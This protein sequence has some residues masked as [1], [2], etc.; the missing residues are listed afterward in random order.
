MQDQV[1]TRWEHA[2]LLICSKIH[3]TDSSSSGWVARRAGT[4]L[5]RWH[6]TKAA[7]SVPSKGLVQSMGSM[8]EAASLD[9]AVITSGDMQP[10]NMADSSMLRDFWH[11]HGNDLETMHHLIYEVVGWTYP[12]NCICTYAG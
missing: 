1:K 11:E 9:R 10:V 2:C 7:A 4:R 6:S 3:R 5:A 12:Q 8:L